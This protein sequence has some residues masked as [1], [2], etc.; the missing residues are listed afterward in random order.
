MKTMA[1][2]IQVSVYR[3]QAFGGGR[4]PAALWR[5]LWF[6]HLHMGMLAISK[7]HSKTLSA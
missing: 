3:I 5:A 1:P 7:I 2:I 4:D 6:S